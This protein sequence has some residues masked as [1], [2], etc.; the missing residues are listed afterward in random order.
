MLRNY[1]KVG[2]VQ[3]RT[4]YHLPS[5]GFHRVRVEISDTGI[6]MDSVMVN[7]IF[8][9]FFQADTSY[10]RRF[11]G[12]GLGLAICKK[13]VELMGGE[14]GI[15]SKPDE[16]STFWFE[17][18]AVVTQNLG[19]TSERV[20][21]TNHQFDQLDASFRILIV[22]DVE[23]NATFLK[24]LLDHIGVASDVAESGE[25]AMRFCKTN[26][27][28]CIL[29]DLAMPGMDGFEVAEWVRHESKLNQKTPILAVSA[30]VSA[31]A[32][33]RC[34]EVGMQ[35]HISKPIDIGELKDALSQIDKGDLVWC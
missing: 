10:T 21:A 15:E 35:G 9:P 31:H 14:I 20:I 17:I 23:A 1:T 6:G 24:T 11:E 29:M 4:G 8:S 30:D 3:L 12:A 19:L 22:D 5:R 2:S 34:L 27:Y 13:L 26:T 32:Q 16:G 33:N 7:K 28:G 25:A 18:P